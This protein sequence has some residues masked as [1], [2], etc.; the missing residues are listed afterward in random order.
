MLWMVGILLPEAAGELN[1]QW[2]LLGGAL[3]LLLGMMLPLPLAVRVVAFVAISAGF[4]WFAWAWVLSA[5]DRHIA[6][7]LLARGRAAVATQ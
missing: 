3:V 5:A 2:L 1:K 4:A 7:D 6:R